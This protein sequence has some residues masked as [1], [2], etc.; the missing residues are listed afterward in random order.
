MIE[1]EPS[2]ALA[3][4][5]HHNPGIYA[6]IVGSGLSRAAGIPT[7]WEITLDLVRR[8]ATLEGS[9]ELQDMPAWF[10]GRFGKAPNYSEILDSLASTPSDRRAILHSYIEPG[11][12]EES[13]RPT[14]AHHAL[15]Q[16]VATGTVR[17]II[18]TNFDRLIENALR[19]AGVE[20]TVISS[21]DSLVGATPLVH[22][23]CTVIKLHGDYLDT[24]IKNTDA[25]L[26]SYSPAVNSLLDEVFDRFGLVVVGW[27][28]DWDAALRAAML[29]TPSRRYPLFWASRSEPGALAKDIIAQ[30]VGHSLLIS[31][32]DAFFTKL[33]HALEALR[34]AARPHPNSV[35]M[36]LALAKR[37]CRDDRFGLEW[38]E[39]LAGEVSRIRNF[40]SGSEYPSATP[41]AENVN[42]LVTTLVAR[43]EILRRISTI[44]G[45]WGTKEN[46]K[47]LDRAIQSLATHDEGNGGFVYWSSLRNFPAALC[48]YWSLAGAL[49]TDNYVAMRALMYT[50]T[51]K[52]NQETPLILN[53]PLMSFD[54]IDWKMLKGFENKKTPASD[55]LHG[56]FVKEL[57]DISIDERDAEALFDQQEFIISLEYA[58]RRLGLMHERDLWFWMPFGRFAWKRGGDH[59]YEQ[60]KKYESLDTNSDIL[61]AGLLGGTPTS[62]QAAVDAM[63]KR[64]N[65][66]PSFRL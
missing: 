26:S 47:A 12:D 13:R 64:Y 51:K 50:L 18:T 58:H 56:L 57:S 46:Q 63:R 8:L 44:C 52:N 39:L 14:K 45:R 17:V 35:E 24:R 20:P 10:Q 53:L 49:A 59:I 36:A 3:I 29:R 41:N 48:F 5:L 33:C 19:E 60:L 30:R 11:P 54:Q 42:S 28:G 31:D 15:A 62:A 32:A 65:E 66:I 2:D 61:R 34:H 27:S 7:G 1:L 38:T 25:E 37:Y 21:E 43:T 55:F 23:R 4:S 16:L 9:A 40:I 22:A 6:V